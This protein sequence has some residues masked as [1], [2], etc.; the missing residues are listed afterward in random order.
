MENKTYAMNAKTI[1]DAFCL[2]K[3]IKSPGDKVFPNVFLKKHEADIFLVTPSGYLYEYEVKIT[4]SDFFADFKKTNKHDL[5]KSGR[6]SN[7]FTY[8]TPKD[9][10]KLDEIPRYAGLIEVDCIYEV[11]VFKFTERFDSPS[12]KEP[13][14]MGLQS[15]SAIKLSSEKLGSMHLLKL[16]ESTYYRFHAFNREKYKK[17]KTDLK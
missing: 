11:D 4:R 6:R 16:Y 15:K 10:V 13:R 3:A 17:E 8:I 9:L 12:W 2:E 5:V 14:L 7:Y 1:I